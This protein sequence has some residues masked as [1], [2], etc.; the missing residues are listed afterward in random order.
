VIGTGGEILTNSHVVEGCQA[1]VVKLAARNTE[2]AALVTS[3]EKNDLALLRLKNV[4]NPLPSVAAFREGAPVRSGDAIVALGYPLSGLLSSDANLSVGNVSALAGLRDD[5]RYLQI[6]APV[7]PGNSGGPLLDASGH[8]VG[9]V[10]AKLDA[11][12][13]ARFTGDI[14]QNVNFALKTEIVRTFLDSKNIAYQT[15]SSDKQLSPA[16]VGDIGR[17]FTVHISCERANLQ[18]A[19]TSPLANPPPKRI[20]ATQQQINSCNGMPHADADL[21]IEGCTAVIQSERRAWAFTNR[22]TAY[23]DKGNIDRAIADFNQAVQIEPKYALAYNNRGV[24]YR[25]RGDFDKAIADF[26]EAI[27]LDP[28]VLAYTNRGW[29]YYHKSDNDHAIGDF[30]QAIAL[31]PK[32]ANAWFGRGLANLYAG[33][34]SQAQTDLDTS[35]KVD[36]KDPYV[37]IWLHIAQTRNKVPSSLAAAMTCLDMTKWPA[38]VARLYIGES[39]PAAVFA[40]AN[41]AGDKLKRGQICE[42][43]F[44]G[45]EFLLQ[46]GMKAQSIKVF[47]L[48]VANCP[49]D[50]IERSAARAEL[51]ALGGN[52]LRLLDH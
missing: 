46:Q 1:I 39:T 19:A 21:M 26:T 43:K 10:T 30:N 23:F 32:S 4:T 8:L 17:P 47:Q 3:D 18:S 35:S 15:A 31:D 37:A 52:P 50:F 29:T 38:P 5:S 42:A 41:R 27:T 45:G 9:I 33:R 36:C 51:K 28:A 34:M 14:P 6:S 44:Y 25:S 48:A 24:A 49:Q 20:A 40:A 11:M 7:Q 2:V 22:G 13:L 16:D 12:R